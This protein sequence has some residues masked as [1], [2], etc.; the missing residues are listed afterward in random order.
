[1]KVTLDK[2]N[3]KGDKN[4]TENRLPHFR[5]KVQDKELIDSGLLEEEKKGYGSQ[6]GDRVLP[7]LMQ[8]VYTRNRDNTELKTV[9]LENENLKATFLTEF[10]MRLYS[11]Y[12]KTRKKDLLY[13][14]PIMQLAN[15]AI[16]RAWFS[17]GVEWNIGQLGHTFSTC[18]PMHVAKGV[19]AQGNEFVRT[20]E[21]ERC[22]KLFWAIDFHLPKGAKQL[23]VYVKIINN[24]PENVPMYW[25]SNAAVNEDKGVR[26]F[27]G[28]NNVIF[29]SESSNQGNQKGMAHGEIPYLS[30]LKGKDSSYPANYN[31]SCEYFFQNEEELTQAWEAAVFNDN[32]MYYERSSKNLR[33]RK[34]FC[35]GIHNGGKH[36]QEFLTEKGT[37][38]YVELQAGL[39]PTQVHGIEMPAESEWDFVQLFGG[40][41]IEYSSV[42][43]E[44][45]KSKDLVYDKINEEI[46][47]T[48]V[49]I[50][51]QKYRDVFLNTDV[52]VISHGNGFGAVEH[53]R[54]GGDIPKGFDF[55][56]APITDAERPWIELIKT[57]IMTDNK[58]FELPL[59]Y[60]VDLRYEDMLTAAAIAG[61]FTAYNHLG[62]MYEE[63]S[64]S[65]KA[66]E[67]FISS[68]KIA[69]NPLAYRNLYIL[70]K[71]ENDKNAIELY[72]KAI[73][74][75]GD[76]LSREYAEE[77]IVALCNHGQYKKAKEFF[78]GLSDEI[79]KGD[80]VQVNMLEVAAQ[81]HDIEYMASVF[82][83][84]FA[85]I[86]EGE[87]SI[88]DYYFIY[89]AICDAAQNGTEV[90][91]ELVE[92]YKKENKIPYDLDFRLSVV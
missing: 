72:D 74:L 77:Y 55:I 80:R 79:A 4:I 12:D 62:V 26:V 44:W 43:G 78:D 52:E 50:A 64:M 67:A 3:L 23:A 58:P 21:Y 81:L 34:M 51:L 32:T 83:K 85:V 13:V 60:M 56:S 47:D 49:E 36:W 68:N 84:E 20:F 46:N 54:S 73:E 91:D 30:S 87:R 40:C 39:A 86:R 48:E 63:N 57:G 16:R 2:I 14:N 22:K 27:S 65:Q 31:Y 7:Y 88:S 42:D 75:L 10:G 66:R 18:E 90:T 38:P 92:K 9:V 35:W 6:T 59:S 69:D 11:L 1:M 71:N 24:R 89:Q 76:N 33:Y 45:N 5:D 25:W 17:G 53:E 29:I 15:L 37:V 28:N 8:D 70:A 19:D 61:S 82:N 41:D